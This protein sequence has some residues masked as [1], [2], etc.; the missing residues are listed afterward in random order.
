[1]AKTPEGEVKDLV[2]KVL[3]KYSAWSRMIVP[4][5]FGSTVGMS[6]FLIVYYGHFIVVETKPRTG[7]KKPTDKQTEFMNEVDD[8]G[9]TSLVVR[10]EED[11]TRL[12]EILNYAKKNP[13]N[14]TSVV[15]D[16]QNAG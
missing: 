11:I 5:R 14:N 16:I 9:G 8:A 7:K 1:V 15:R 2:K 3:R 6:D 13:V 4:S 10:D 12:E